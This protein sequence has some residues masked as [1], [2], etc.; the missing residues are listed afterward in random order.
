MTHCR[1]RGADRP[2]APLNRITLWDRHGNVKDWC[3]C[4]CGRRYRS[5]DADAPDHL[6]EPLGAD[7]EPP[8]GASEAWPAEMLRAADAESEFGATG[9]VPIGTPVLHEPTRTVGRITDDVE[10]LARHLVKGMHHAPGVGLAANQVGMPVRMFVQVHRR[11]APETFVDP[12]IRAEGGTWHYNEGCLSL[13]VEGSHHD[14]ARP[15]RVQV[16]ARNLRGETFEITAD[17]VLARILQHEIDHLDGVMYVQRTEPPA[18][19]DLYALLRDVGIDT[20]VV[21]PKPYIP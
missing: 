3:T 21:P 4:T 9:V 19:N 17:E 14:I 13:V 2:C 18:R 7:S 6:V 16:R 10:A 12:I 11:A 8:T 15:R 5:S 1:A 20:A